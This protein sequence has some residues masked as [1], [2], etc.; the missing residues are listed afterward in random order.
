MFGSSGSESVVKLLPNHSELIRTNLNLK[1]KL[2][3][4]I[5]NQKSKIQ[6]RSPPLGIYCGLECAD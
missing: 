2:Q 4:Q 3:S 1:L 6:Q 5:K